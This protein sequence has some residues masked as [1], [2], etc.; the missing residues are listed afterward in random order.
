MDSVAELVAPQGVLLLE[1]VAGPGEHS[2]YL[3]RLPRRSLTRLLRAPTHAV[4][5]RADR[6]GFVAEPS[7][8]QETGGFRRFD[9]Q[10]LG[11]RFRSKGWEVRET[12]AV[13]PALGA[14]PAAVDAVRPDPK[15]WAHLIELEEIV[16]ARPERWR[17]AAAVLLALAPGPPR[18]TIK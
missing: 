4:I 1:I 10:T 8:K 13:A 18:G 15:A 14:V 12:I 9:P 11:G 6:E 5:A 3:S 16:G 2:Q 7:R 17:R